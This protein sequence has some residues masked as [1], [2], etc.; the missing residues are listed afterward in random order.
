MRIVLLIAGVLLIHSSVFSQ[1]SSEVNIVG[2]LRDV[3]WNGQLQGQVYIDTIPD[4][5]HLY[6]MGPL[7]YLAGEITII[8]GKTYQSKAVSQNEM[9]VEETTNIRAPFLGYSRIPRWKELTLPDSVRTIEMLEQ[10]LLNLVGE[11]AYPFMFKLAGII[12]QAGIH[13]MNLPE[14]SAVSSPKDA[15]DT[16]VHYEINNENCDIVGFFSVSHQTI[17]THH[18]SFVHMHLITA[19]RTKMGHLDE[20]LFGS[21]MK[22][23]LP[24]AD[25]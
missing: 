5:D 1:K 22:L 7:E 23:Y 11:S 6:G 10:Y 3:M 2:A 16:M 8:E 4:Q 17:F 19:D 12:E 15:H 20:I 24:E 13:I 18:D 14:G 25:F 9:W 21:D